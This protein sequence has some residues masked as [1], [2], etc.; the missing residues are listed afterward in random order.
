MK[1][2]ISGLLV[3]GSLLC[4]GF[5]ASAAD[6]KW[7]IS[8]NTPEQTV[9]M[10]QLAKTYEDSHLGTK[11]VIQVMS[12]EAYKAKL[13]TSLQSPDR[14]DLFYT[15]GG[16]VMFAQADAGLLQDISKSAKGEWNDSLSPAAVAAMSYKGKQYG[17]PE[18][19]SVVALW[20]NKA[21]FAKAGVD[22]K[23]LATWDG[24][25]DATKAFKAA[26]I[27]PFG[28]GGSDKWPVSMIWDAL[29]L[30][31][32]GEPAFMGAMNRTGPGFDG[33]DFL[34]ASQELKRLA[35]LEPFQKGFLGDT[36]PQAE[37]QFGDGKSAMQVMGNWF[38]NIQ[39]T[40]SVSQKGVP[41]SDLGW[42]PFPQ[43]AGGKG[44]PADV[45]G[46][47]NGY[48]VTKSAP[49][50]AIDFLRYYTSADVQRQAA[51]R[52]FYITVAK[53]T[54]VDVQNRFYREMATG[55]QSARYVQN[56]YDQM[57]G[58]NTGRVVNDATADL[59]AGRIKPAEVGKQIQDTWDLDR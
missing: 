2:R 35:D 53:G 26:G 33:P 17:A 54:D 43:V 24:V 8:E 7:F 40:Q 51:K 46:G 50:E 56:F 32:G 37:G 10:R 36:A 16:G 1:L 52:G 39:R 15:W 38:Y 58:P 22:P 6:V 20:Y 14:P 42:A 41:D 59:V 34:K 31:I 5:G 57:L 28:M 13:T 48:L 30:R 44:N 23:S 12:G 18:H 45:V 4:A 19:F 27:T 55:L 29:A 21:L 25:L 3:A 49:P 9:W 11:I 47:V